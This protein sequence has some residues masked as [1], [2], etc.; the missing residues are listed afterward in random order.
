MKNIRLFIWDFDGTLIDTYPHI[1]RYLKLALQD[2]GHDAD[3]V[4]ILDK[5][6]VTIPHAVN[7]YA[8]LYSLKELDLHFEKYKKAEKTDPVIPF[9]YVKEVLE[10][11][12]EL[13]GINCIFTNRGRAAVEMIE[14]AGLSEEFADIVTASDPSF[15]VK[16]APD[17]IIYLMEKH[18]VA[19]EQ[20][21]MIGDRRCD[22]ESG[23]NAKCKTIH[24][25]TPA[26]PDYPPC[27]WRINGFGEMLEML[28]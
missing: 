1:T 4:E 14:S 21:A 26:V 7:Y 2:L 19:P 23:Y 3:Q 24:L 25:L 13:G 22:L 5:M 12:R 11:I 6:M 16:P 17:T 27:D 28:K 20:T 9:P 8:D 15:K 10:R 18:G